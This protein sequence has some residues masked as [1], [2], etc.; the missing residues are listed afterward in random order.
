MEYNIAFGICTYNR[1]NVLLKSAASLKRIEGLETV[2]IRI[3]DDCST[4]YDKNFLETVF[5]MAESIH[6]NDTNVGADKN[7]S[8]MY[9]DFLSS[10]DDILLNADSDL[11][12]APNIIREIQNEV[13]KGVRFFSMFNTPNHKILGILSN[14]F[15]EKRTVGAAGCVL[16]REMVKMV[17]EGIEDKT[18][19]FDTNMCTLLRNKGYPIIVT[20]RSYVQHIGISGQ[21]SDLFSFDYGMGFEYGTKENADAIEWAFEMYIKNISDFKRSTFGRWVGL[22]LSLYRKFLWVKHKE[23]GYAIKKVGNDT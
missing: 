7:T 13:N 2:H 20:D 21:N 23:R 18:R 14:G 5:P 1:K 3:Y 12:Y 16:T 19:N 10:E 9:E 22:W 4:E 8:L 11:L 15:V 17:T 6:M